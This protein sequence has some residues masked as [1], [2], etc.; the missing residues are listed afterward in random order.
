MNVANKDY[1]Y[2][3]MRLF[4]NDLEAQLAEVQTIIPTASG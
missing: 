3:A 1:D 2:E 4:L